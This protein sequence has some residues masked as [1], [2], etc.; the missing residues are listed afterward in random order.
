LFA[1]WTYNG[2]VLIAAPFT[3]DFSCEQINLLNPKR[4][5]GGW[6]PVAAIAALC[7]EDV[8]LSSFAINRF[9]S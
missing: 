6:P 1:R 8:H 7:C 9:M 4:Q 2:D 5:L 3:F